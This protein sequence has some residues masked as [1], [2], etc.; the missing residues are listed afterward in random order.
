M[1]SLEMFFGTEEE[2]EKE[3]R[4]DCEGFRD[5]WEIVNM[6]LGVGVI[7]TVWECGSEL[8]SKP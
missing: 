2:K 3:E 1:T 8:S 4:A 7:Y 5:C 6:E